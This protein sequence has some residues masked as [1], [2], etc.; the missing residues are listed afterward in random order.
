MATSASLFAHRRNADGSCGSICRACFAVVAC[1]AREE[2]LAKH[3]KAH[4]CDSSFLADRGTL[5]RGES[6]RRSMLAGPG[7]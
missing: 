7:Q 5:H 4:A 3:E 2:E 6:L 1:S